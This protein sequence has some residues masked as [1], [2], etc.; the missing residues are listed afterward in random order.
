MAQLRDVPHVLRTVGVFGFVRRV[1]KQGSDDQLMT[2]AAAL[3][4]SWLFAVFPFFI[5]LMTLVPY[6]PLSTKDAVRTELRDI[7]YLSPTPAADALWSNVET[8]LLNPTP[9]SVWLRVGG[10]VLA[11]WAA[12]GGMAMTMNALDKCYELKEGRAFHRH[13]SL[14]MALTVVIATLVLLV[15]VLLPVGGVVKAWII[16]QQ[17]PGLHKGSPW[18]IAFDVARWALAVPFMVSILTV[19]YHWGPNVRH[20]FHWVTPGAVFSIVVWVTLG[21]AFKL[22]LE[23]FLNY[24]KT[25]GTVGGAAVLLLFFY[26]DAAVLLWG[27]EINSEIDFEVL[28]VRRGTRDFLPAEAAAEGEAVV[29]SPAAHPPPAL[30]RRPSVLVP[31]STASGDPL[32]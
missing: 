12:S 3:A 16:A 18:L 26:I 28:K 9:G 10:L 19:L 22:Y 11:L 25:Y 32:P 20:R 24:N 5:F 21:L 29:P 13:R 30:E 4:Y 1:W 31:T 14:A 2:W 7:V 6:L 8:H 23:R 27:A 17:W 15:V